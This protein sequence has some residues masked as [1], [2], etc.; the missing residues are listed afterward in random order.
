[1]DANLQQC[2]AWGNSGFWSCSSMVNS[3]QN[4]SAV[5]RCSLNDESHSGNHRLPTLQLRDDHLAS[6]R[7]Y[8]SLYGNIND[9]LEEVKIETSCHWK[10]PH[11]TSTVYS[12]L[13]ERVLCWNEAI[14]GGNSFLGFLLLR[15]GQGCTLL[16]RR[17]KIPQATQ[18]PAS[19][20]SK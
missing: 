15:E 19:L 18:A 7:K 10:I 12:L 13:S 17:R 2:S 9:L 5:L 16:F 8:K 20:R 4:A 11:F 1:M 14:S 6:W 3:L